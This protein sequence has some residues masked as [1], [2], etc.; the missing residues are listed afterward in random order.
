MSFIILGLYFSF[1]AS[2][3]PLLR[4]RKTWMPVSWWEQPAKDRQAVLKEKET[5]VNLS[6]SFR[7]PSI[8]WLDSGILVAHSLHDGT[9]PSP[10]S[11]ICSIVEVSGDVFISLIA[12]DK[13]CLAKKRKERKDRQAVLKDLT[14][15]RKF[16]VS[17][18]PTFQTH[19]SCWKKDT[20][21]TGEWW[22]VNRFPSLLQIHCL[23]IMPNG[24]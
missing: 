19:S 10:I 21:D 8:S 15:S 2:D 11:F 5:A 20:E 14:S 9:V 4:K 24:V 23:C 18:V 1:L 16:S 22:T 17:C 3:R 6:F 13:H 7:T 12:R